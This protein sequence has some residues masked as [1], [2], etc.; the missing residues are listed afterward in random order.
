MGK[1]GRVEREMRKMIRGRIKRS[2]KNI[3]N[4]RGKREKRIITIKSE[5]KGERRRETEEEGRGR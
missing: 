3:A 4:K 1:E 5:I 2:E